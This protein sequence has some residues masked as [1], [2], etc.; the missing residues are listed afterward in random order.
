MTPFEKILFKCDLHHQK[1]FILG[2][3][4]LFNRIQYTMYLLKYV[5]Y[6]ENGA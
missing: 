1:I 4:S 2:E 6:V 5:W 3:S